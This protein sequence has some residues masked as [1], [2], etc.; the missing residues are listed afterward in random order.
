MGFRFRRSVRLFPGVRL[1]FSGGGIST[2]LGVRGASINVGPRGT[3]ANLGLPGTGLSYRAHLS[4]PQP[5]ELP[6]TP[7]TLPV[8]SPPLPLAPP[9]AAS[10]PGAIASAPIEFLTSRGLGELKRLINEAAVKRITLGHA[11]AGK[12]ASLAAAGRRLAFARAFLIRIVL[13]RTVPARARAVFDAESARDEAAEELAACVID[14]DF[15]FDTATLD[16]F[17]ALLRTYEVLSAAQKI[18]DI[19]ASVATN[20]VVERTTAAQRVSRSQVVFD[21]ARSD[22]VE[23]KYQALRLGNANGYDI[24][25]YPG[26]VMM[27]SRG[28]D[29]AIV[30]FNEFTVGFTPSLFIEEDAVPSDAEIVGKDWKKANKDGSR[31]RRF[32]D[33]YQIPVVRYGRLDFASPT[34]VR[35]VYQISDYGKTQSFAEAFASYRH[36]LAAAAKAGHAAGTAHEEIV[37]PHEEAVP[38]K[39]FV[40]PQPKSLV[41]DFIALAVLAVLV[42]A[43][44][45]FAATAPAS[46]PLPTAGIASPAAQPAVRLIPAPAVNEAVRVT[47]PR[48]NIR[49]SPA[50]Q[51]KVAGHARKGQILYVF[52]RSGA[53]I[54]VGDDKPQGWMLA[55][56]T[57]PAN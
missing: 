40:P 42:A 46:P 7:P 31:D 2:T 5:H 6:S 15:D 3:Y 26:F 43:L 57:A 14:V 11:L 12:E 19:T 51:A 18:W 22:I 20:R 56:L 13:Q 21:F 41:F 54:R 10:Q 8:S 45:Y 23:S 9:V 28:A 17:A 24:L 47:A 30:D 50:R 29:F 27:R 4:S 16:K 33:N 55:S 53:W 39:V 37:L 32:R 52:G 44:A 25:I 38:E 48:A 1:N 35:E 34:G 36:A 49:V